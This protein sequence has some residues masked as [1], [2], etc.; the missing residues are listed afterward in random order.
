MV[1]RWLGSNMEPFFI[2]SVL[3][4]PGAKLDEVNVNIIKYLQFN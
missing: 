3:S 1:H 4:W 2:S